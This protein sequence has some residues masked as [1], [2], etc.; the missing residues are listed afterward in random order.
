MLSV[1]CFAILVVC[2]CRL[3]ELGERVLYGVRLLVLGLERLLG[4]RIGA[5]LVREDTQIQLCFH[6]TLSEATFCLFELV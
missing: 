5:Y 6:H 4:N 1:V 3:R 2:Q